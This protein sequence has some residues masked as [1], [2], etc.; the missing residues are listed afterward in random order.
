M[1]ALRLSEIDKL[2]ADDDQNNFDIMGLR[3]KIKHVYSE[4]LDYLDK[5]RNMQERYD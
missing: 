3:E 4:K 5:V 2:R 1:V